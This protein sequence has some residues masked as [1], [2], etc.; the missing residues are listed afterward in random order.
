VGVKVSGLEESSDDDWISGSCPTTI[1]RWESQVLIGVY[2][3]E[4]GIPREKKPSE[5]LPHPH[6]MIE[7]LP[8]QTRTA[9]A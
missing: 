8:P 5:A 1:L 3:Q 7:R 9:P 6:T 2:D 4:I